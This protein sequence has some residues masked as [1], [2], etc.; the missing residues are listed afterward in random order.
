MAKE[1]DNLT[2]KIG[3]NA[4]GQFWY[5]V[6][7]GDGSKPGSLKRASGAV[8]LETALSEGGEQL[9]RWIVIKNCKHDWSGLLGELP[10]CEKCGIV[11]WD[12]HG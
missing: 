8:D 6:Y 10:L 1:I 2:L 12:Y 3:Q 5:A 4:L 11:D 7:D 9:A